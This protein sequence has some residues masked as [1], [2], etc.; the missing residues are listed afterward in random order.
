MSTASMGLRLL[1]GFDLLLIFLAAVTIL[2][3]LFNMKKHGRR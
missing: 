1:L 2:A 3:I